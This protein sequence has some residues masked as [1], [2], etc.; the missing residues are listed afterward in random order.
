MKTSHPNVVVCSASRVERHLRYAQ[1]HRGERGVAASCAEYPTPNTLML[2][3][4]ED[5]L[6][7]PRRLERVSDR[8]ERWMR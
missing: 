6:G 5:I 2:E 3:L 4:A 7:T 1:Y 8:L